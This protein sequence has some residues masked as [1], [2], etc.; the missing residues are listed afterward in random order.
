MAGPHS[1]LP[2]IRYVD[3]DQWIRENAPGRRHT[4][5]EILFAYR[6]R[7]AEETAAGTSRRPRET[8]ED[9]CRR[10]VGAQAMVGVHEGLRR[11]PPEDEHGLGTVVPRSGESR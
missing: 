11:S 10:F 4:H 8:M 6:R 1:T 7:R 3:R 9:Q 2:E 5:P